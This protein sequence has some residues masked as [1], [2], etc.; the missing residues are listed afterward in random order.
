MPNVLSD[1]QEISSKETKTV[2]DFSS[3]NSD[4]GSSYKAFQNED[5][6][7]ESKQL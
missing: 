1:E 3:K 5:Q 4:L 6:Q 2:F 7:V